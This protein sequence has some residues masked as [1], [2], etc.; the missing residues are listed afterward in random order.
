[1][2]KLTLLLVD[3]WEMFSEGLVNLLKLESEIEAV[4]WITTVAEAVEAATTHKPDVILLDIEE[5]GVE[6][7]QRLRQIMP[8]VP[9]IIFTVSRSPTDFF[10][11]IRAGATGYVFKK[12]NLKNLVKTLTLAVDGQF[13]I[14]P[15]MARIAID[16]LSCLDE[17]R[18]L[19]QAERID[20]LTEQERVVMALMRHGATN[21]RI[22]STLFISESTVKMHIRNIMRKLHARSR[23][24]AIVCAIEQSLPNQEAETLEAEDVGKGSTD[25]SGIE[26]L[27]PTTMKRAESGGEVSKQPAADQQ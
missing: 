7:I 12:S 16:A 14:A 20:S 24:E 1:M 27:E 15:P 5:S 23:L 6:T 26:T 2:T 13:I 25:S 18:H 3:S 19:A 17:H 21:E 10:S 8:Q 22:T 11:A 4:L 9:I